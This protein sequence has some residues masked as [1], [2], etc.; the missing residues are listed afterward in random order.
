VEVCAVPL[1]KTPPP[2]PTPPSPPTPTPSTLPAAP[3]PHD[4]AVLNFLSVRGIHL[5]PARRYA[6]AYTLEGV[7]ALWKKMLDKPKVRD[8][9]ALFNSILNQNMPTEAK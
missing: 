4:P 3:A 1:K 6:A 9:A 7:Q 8:K 5:H 2:T